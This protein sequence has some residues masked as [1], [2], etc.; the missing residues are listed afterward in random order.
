MPK[1]AEIVLKKCLGLR[2]D[3]KVLIVTDSKLYEIGKKFFAEAKKITKNVELVKIPI[4]N[5]H[6]TEPS[7]KISQEMLK[8]E[9]ELLITT[10]S[11]SH[12]NAR[13]N[14]SR[15]GARIVSMP[16][17]TREILA[18]CIDVDYDAMKKR[19]KKI[20][21][22]LTRGK[23]IKVITKAGTDIEMDISGLKCFGENSGIY[24]KRGD[25]GNLPEGEA[26]MA[27]K[28]GTANGIFVVDASMS[29]IGKVK[30]PIKIT[31]KKGFAVLIEG[32]E[33]AEQLKKLLK[34]QNDKSVYNTAEIGI[35]T[36]DK[37][38]I[39]GITLEDEKVLGTAHIAL[40][41]NTSYDGGKTKSSVHLDGVFNGPTIIADGKKIMDYGKLLVK[42]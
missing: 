30:K 39:S 21:D 10:K 5:V 40:G 15:K 19:T 35:G 25:W 3:E 18:R 17:I 14:A 6:G 4:P 38:K 36:N 2:K 8:Y 34:R 42:Y 1:P 11:L 32:G 20:A 16:G 9:V 24:V 41:D 31:V 12:T 13:R 22:A 23:K 28:E 7:R 37:A 29:G 26:C 33:E 27:P